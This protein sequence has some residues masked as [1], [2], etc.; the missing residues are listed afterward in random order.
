MS[1]VKVVIPQL[2]IEQN[3]QPLEQVVVKG[4]KNITYNTLTPDT[5]NDNNMM[6]SFQPPSQNTI[7]DRRILLQCSVDITN[8][9][10]G[11]TMAS[12]VMRD[13]AKYHIVSND[14]LAQFTGV[15]GAGAATFYEPEKVNNP[16]QAGRFTAI[17]DSILAPRQLPL[18]S[19]IDVIDIEINGTH[20][21]VSPKDYIH[22]LLRYTTPEFRAKYLSETAHYPDVFED[23]IG[24]YG[25]DDHPLSEKTR[26]GRKG[27]IPRGSFVHSS[28]PAGNVLRYTFTEPLFIS[29]LLV[30]GLHE[31]LT[32]VNQMNISVRW[33]SG[34]L[35]RM[36][37]FIP[38]AVLGASF[39]EPATTRALTNANLSVSFV[40]TSAKLLVNFL[41][42]QDDIKIP[43]QVVYPYSQPQLYKKVFNGLALG[44]G[45]VSGDLVG[46]N[47]RIN[48]IPE[49]MYIILQKP[50]G[51]KEI[52]DADFHLAVNKVNINWNNQT[53]ILSGASPEQLHQLNKENGLD[54]DYNEYRS[55]SGANGGQN[56]RFGVPLCLEFGKDIPLET[57]ETIGMVGNYNLRVDVNAFNCSENVFAN[58]EY[59][60]LLVMKGEVIV[61]PNEMRLSLGNVSVG[62]SMNAE[63]E[64]IEY[65]D[66][67]ATGA[68][69]GL[70]GGGF[71]SGLKHL[72]KRGAGLGNKLA[73][74]CE[75][76]APMVK[77]ASAT[78]EKF[79]GGSEVGGS[80]VG[81]SFVGGRMGRKM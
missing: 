14:N 62:D 63:K 81:G 46:D 48:Q 21:S 42:P 10:A 24:T 66:I 32:N 60:I 19:C 29:P 54:V 13:R 40:P 30:G 47:I 76:Y 11:G 5:E 80:R 33:D 55:K 35:K 75:K 23:Y 52:S 28:N 45:V 56:R 3:D 39:A 17:R 4:V 77:K 25:E 58:L 65:K 59:S 68:L 74:A 36:F 12:E 70:D 50:V 51:N 34:N 41:T 67:S 26:S 72:V 53:G 6:W 38:D 7:I 15:G 18:H 43:S 1:A 22:T 31:G 64:G 27:E 9:I 71:L 8:T 57:G 2:D 49:K 44:A 37:S 16:N 69:G 73:S 61:A 79:S 20:I 78:A